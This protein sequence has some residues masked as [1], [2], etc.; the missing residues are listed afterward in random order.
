MERAD[1][2]M[3]MLAAN[4]LADGMTGALM[5]IGIVGVR[6]IREGEKVPRPASS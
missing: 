1:H 5:T 4:M 2:V 3:L 6:I